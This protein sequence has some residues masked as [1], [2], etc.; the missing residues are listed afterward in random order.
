MKTFLLNGCSFGECWTPTNN[1]IADLGCDNVTNISK[2]AT[3]FQRTCRS[4]VEWIA[5]NDKPYFVIVPITFAHRW[6]LAIGKNEDQIDGSWFPLQR[7]DLLDAYSDQL[8]NDVN[9]QKVKN[10]L[11]L[12]YGTIP[13]IKTYW[14]KLFSEVI[15]LSSFLES[16]SIRH[17]F[18]DMCNEFDM[19]HIKGY[20]GF[21]KVKLI[22]SNKNIIDLFN[23]CGNR[24]MW[25]SMDDNHNVHFNIHH[26]Q[27]Q[28]KHLENYLSNYINQ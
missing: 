25:K 22:D 12:Y 11:D 9:V 17:L 14:D 24:Y 6:E 27:D 8:H 1:F 3:S 10:M 13:T 26:A 18:F 23:F 2:P 28:Y 16:K 20:K 21:D 4:T 19:K 7:K 15:M 5:Q